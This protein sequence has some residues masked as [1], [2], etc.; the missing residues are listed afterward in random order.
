MFGYVTLDG[1]DTAIVNFITGVDLSDLDAAA[2]FLMTRPRV[3]AI[4]KDVREG[5]ITDFHFEI[6]RSQR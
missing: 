6:V 2:R 5:R 3:T 1:A 4:F